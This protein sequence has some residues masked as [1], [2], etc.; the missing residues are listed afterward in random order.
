MSFSVP[1]LDIVISRG[2]Q[3]NCQGCLT[4][5]N[6][7]KVKGFSSLDTAIPWLEFW[8][9]KLQAQTIHLF[10]GEPLMNPDFADWVRAVSKYFIRDYKVQN[11]CCQTNGI[12]L[13]SI[14]RSVL[15]ELI[16]VHK[17]TF[18]ITIHSDEEWYQTKIKSA[19]ELVTD[20][21]G[22]GDWVQINDTE[23]LYTNHDGDW[24]GFCVT[25]HSAEDTRRS[26]VSYYTGY[27]SS[28]RPGFDF[29]SENYSSNHG[30]C[31][32]KDYLQLYEGALYKCP[33]MAV[34]NHALKTYN[35]P[36]RESWEPW[37]NYKYLPA[38]ADDVQIESWLETQ[39]QPERYCNMC[40]G[41]TVDFKN[42][43]LKVKY[44]DD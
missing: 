44:K 32:I 30:Y 26:W 27:G 12:K 2:C 24:V 20:I 41:A 4:Y 22:P 9:N 43:S 28:L 42:H 40:F 36:N 37:L 38:G 16:H 10:G 1:K 6:H 5:S 7:N 11:L 21:L 23:R 15:E 34:V 3:L 39:K 19:I 25:D 14:D 13:A 17:L 35:Y 18:N 29:S 31:G 8:G 33:P